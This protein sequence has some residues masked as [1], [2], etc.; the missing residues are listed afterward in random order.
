MVKQKR[1]E[2]VKDSHLEKRWE[3]LRLKDSEMDLRM[4]KPMDFLKQMD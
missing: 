1:W 3:I 4:V 2:T